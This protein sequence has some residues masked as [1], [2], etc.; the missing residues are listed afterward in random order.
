LL[1]GILV[2]ASATGATDVR[3]APDP[4]DDVVLDALQVFELPV[5]GNLGVPDDAAMVATTITTVRPTDAGHVTAY[6]CGSTMPTASNVNYLADDVVPNFALTRLS[7]DGTICVQSHATTDVIVDVVGYVPRG[8]M[9]D[10]L[11]APARARDTR[12]SGPTPR[13]GRTLHLEL[14]GRFG[15][16]R[17]ADT[18]LFNLTAA[19][20]A[21]PGHATVHPCLPHGPPEASSINY[22]PGRTVANFVTARLDA[23][24]AVCI[25]VHSPVDL[26]VDVAGSTRGGVV[27]LDEPVRIADSRE[28]LGATG[29][30]HSTNGLRLDVAGSYGVPMSASAVVYNLT[31]T[32]ARVEGHLTSAPCGAL[33]ASAS[34]LNVVPGRDVAGTTITGIGDDGAVCVA[35]HG[36][37][38]VVADL[39]GYVPSDASYVPLRPQRLWD[40]RLGWHADCRW[41]PSHADDPGV[42]I[43]DV[44]TGA[45]RRL[46][47]GEPNS[48]VVPLRT[49]IV[50]ADCGSVVTVGAGSVR[51]A[52][53]DGTVTT[54][55]FEPEDGWRARDVFEV[56]GRIVA[57]G[58]MSTFG[59]RL[60]DV[61]TQEVVWDHS[62]GIPGLTPS[63]ALATTRILD[64]TPSGYVARIVDMAEERRVDVWRIDDDSLVTD[65]VVPDDVVDME[66]SDAVDRILLVRRLDDR[67]GRFVVEVR[68]PTDWLATAHT[69]DVDPETLQRS[70][71]VEAWFGRNGALV[72]CVPE[73]GTFEEPTNGTMRQLAGTFDRCPT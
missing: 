50:S 26:I 24:G 31:A 37:T 71:G 29:P 35:S 34:N 43:Y 5:A 58:I 62:D 32:R 69:I 56:D 42:T 52:H 14:A 4:R 27:T 64:V 54:E 55:E 73:V 40:T 33:Q 45:E 48:L 49:P 6:P 9:I 39:I 46:I 8:S 70:G 41:R 7:D 28:F 63:W 59:V 18:V 30:I 68:S 36:V 21:A 47:P 51:R 17:D 61:L 10:A 1:A 13:P 25:D 23:D 72:W 2:V 15:V 38:D 19:G 22:I 12:V 65:F 20:A 3:A 16:P 44:D 67:P 53:A 11:D 60:F 57:T 66:V